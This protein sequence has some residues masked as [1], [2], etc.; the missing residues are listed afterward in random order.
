MTRAVHLE[1][2]HDMTTH[3]FLLG[4][5]RFIARHGKSRKIIWDNA[6]QLELA[7]DTLDKLWGQISTQNDVIFYSSK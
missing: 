6:A 1:M 3:E 5:R 7:A 2:M 4:F